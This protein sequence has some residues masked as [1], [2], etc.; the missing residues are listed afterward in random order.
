ETRRATGFSS[1]R[2]VALGERRMREQL[3]AA[4]FQHGGF[5]FQRRADHR[6]ESCIRYIVAGMRAR[7]QETAGEFVQALRAGLES[8]QSAAQAVID[9]LVVAELEMQAGNLFAR[10]PVAAVQGVA[11]GQEQRTGNHLASAARE[12]HVRAVRKCR[13]EVAEE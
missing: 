7:G 5:A 6:A 11:A 4:R 13:T 2:C 9:A 8:E 3:D 12:S 1:R 10:P